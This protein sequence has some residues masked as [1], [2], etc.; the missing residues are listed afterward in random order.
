ML[1][2]RVLLLLVEARTDG[3]TTS[4]RLARLVMDEFEVSIGTG[5]VTL[6]VRGVWY[7][8]PP[9]TEVAGVGTIDVSRLSAMALAARPRVRLAGRMSSGAGEAKR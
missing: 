7:S 4:I 2:W 8:E 9:E 3:R 1:F 6:L 5:V